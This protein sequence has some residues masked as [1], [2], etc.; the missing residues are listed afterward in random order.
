MS[1]RAFPNVVVRKNV[2]CQS[3]RN[4]FGVVVPVPTLIVVHDTEGGNIPHS[5][6]DLDGLADWFNRLTTQASS[7]VGVDEDGQ[8]GRFVPD[9]QKAWA[10]AFFNPPGLSIEQIGFAADDWKSKKKEAE[11]RETARWIA[12]WH[13]RYQI[14]IQAAKVSSSGLIIKPGVIQHFRLG[15]LGGAHHDV[16]K[17]YPTGKVL[18][19]ARHYADLQ[20]N[21]K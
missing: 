4:H 16:S 8:S 3:D 20:E 11:L 9:G 13:R 5:H 19:W 10:Q 21:S 7:H 2:A 6:R 17:N 14:P 1:E 18:R 15:T 12:L